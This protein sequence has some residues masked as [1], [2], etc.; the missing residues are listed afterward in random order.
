VNQNG[1]IGRLE[2]QVL[3]EQVSIL[4]KPPARVFIA[5]TCV[6]DEVPEVARVIEPPQMHQ[7]MDQDVL[8]DALGHQ[9]ETP[10]EADVT[11]R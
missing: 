10:V 3:L 8:A 2:I 4:A 5:G 11:G 6:R 9:D 7:L 1:K